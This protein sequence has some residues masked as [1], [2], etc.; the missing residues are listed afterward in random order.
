MISWG[1]LFIFVKNENIMAVI[2]IVMMVLLLRG[3]IFLEENN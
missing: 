2:G 3:L 1:F